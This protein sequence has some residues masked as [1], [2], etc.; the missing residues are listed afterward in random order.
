MAGT[1]SERVGFI[2]PCLV[3]SPHKAPRVNAEW[4]AT[5]KDWQEA[6]RRYK[7]RGAGRASNDDHARRSTSGS[8]DSGHEGVPQDAPPDYHP[9]MD[10]MRCILYTHGGKTIKTAHRLVLTYYQADIILAV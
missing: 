5:K 9:D 8:T 10:E 1:R 4:I 7:Q 3:T 6:K 2:G